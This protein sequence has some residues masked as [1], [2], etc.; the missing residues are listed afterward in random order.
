MSFYDYHNQLINNISKDNN[1]LLSISLIQ[2]KYDNVDIFDILPQEV[3]FVI[4]CSDLVMENK[5]KQIREGIINCLKK[6]PLNQ[7][8]KFN[9]LQYGS[10]FVFFSKKMLIA[11]AE[12]IN[13]AIEY[14][15][16]IKEKSGIAKTFN[17]L[18]AVLRQS[19]IAILIT[20]EDI[21]YDQELHKIC[22][23]FLKLSVLKIDNHMVNN[24]NR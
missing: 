1:E 19:K 18:N 21:V 12:N 16:T 24:I 4:N 23:Q 13:K 17:A 6:M 8:Y 20:N 5:I 14:C 2:Y 9:I 10:K 15:Q 7:S 22:K 11:N 3:I